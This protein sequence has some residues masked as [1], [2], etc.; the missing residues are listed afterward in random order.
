M[1]TNRKLLIHPS[2]HILEGL[3]IVRDVTFGHEEMEVILDFYVFEVLDFDLMIGIPIEK[4]LTKA[5]TSADFHFTLGKESFSLPITTSRYT[6]T[7][8]PSEEVDEEVMAIFPFES[9][10]AALEKDAEDFIL[11]EAESEETYE[12]P[13]TSPLP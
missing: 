4:L 11:E 9:P 5:P 1:G 8:E 7:E 6:I 10:E 12:L 13:Q 3:G 2:H